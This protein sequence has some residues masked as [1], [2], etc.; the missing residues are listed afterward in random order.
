MRGNTSSGDNFP[1]MP[2][3]ELL[4]SIGT[5]WSPVCEPV[6]PGPGE[7]GVI[8]LS[9]ITSGIFIPSESKK[10]PIDLAPRPKLEIRRGDVLMSRANGVRSLVGVSCVVRDVR[11]RLLLPDLVFRLE[12]YEEQVDSEFLGMALSSVSARSQIDRVTRGTSG[13]FK[14][15]QADVRCLMIPVPSLV[16]QRRIVAAVAALSRDIEAIGRR[17]EKLQILHDALT[18]SVA[19]S[20]L[21]TPL[22]DRTSWPRLGDCLLR[23]EA[24]RSPAAESSPAGPGE[25][26]VLKVSAVRRRWFDFRQNKAVRDAGLINPAFE[27]REG[28]LLMARANTE[29]LLGLA[30]IVRGAVSRLMLSDK[31]LRLVVDATMADPR[32]LELV[33]SFPE[34]RHE[35]QA[36][37][38]GTSGSMKNISR[39]KINNLRIP[40]PSLE[41]QHRAIAI[42]EHAMR[43]V[44]VAEACADKLRVIRGALAEDLLSGRVRVSDL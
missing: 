1:L 36:A 27:V 24:G 42:A 26:G 21:S 16:E 11:Q 9:A 14:V 25:W 28:D 10:L 40:L 37:A 3:G 43:Q 20:G 18:Y 32:Y 6:Q 29:D 19:V 5:G 30:C 44:A 31:T 41:G 33:L 13:Q 12:P 34:I 7:W 39:E 17:I 15:S 8:K 2:L 38:T 23:I 22:A 35:I 4:Q